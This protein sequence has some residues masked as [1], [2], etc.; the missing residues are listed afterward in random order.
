VGTEALRLLKHP[1]NTRAIAH[2]RRSK[3]VETMLT[4]EEH[5]IELKA[6]CDAATA[7]GQLSAAGRAEKLR[8]RLCGYYAVKIEHGAQ[9]QLANMSN[10]ELHR[11]IIDEAQALGIDLSA[12]KIIGKR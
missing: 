9:N 7:S 8:S 1:G 5:M 10:A 6:I 3:V 12:P 4:L 11:F 2:Y